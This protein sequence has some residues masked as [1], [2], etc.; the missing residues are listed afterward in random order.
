MAETDLRFRQVHLDFHTSEAI[1]G[2]GAD[3]DPDEFAATLKR[4][5]VD[6]VTCFAR[7]HHGWIYYDTKAF[8]ERRHPG[9]VRPNLLGEQIDACGRRGIRTPLYVTVQWDHFTAEHYPEWLILRHDG[10]IEG[11]PPFEPGFYRSLCVNTPYRDW[12]KR[13]VQEIFDTVRVD[14]FFFDIVGE[15]PCSCWRC[16]AGMR[17]AGLDPSDAGARAAYAADLMA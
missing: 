5:R 4:A 2:V 3:F 15:R 12:L 16:K 7:C 13:H 14:G 11:T 8:P 1:G 10:A 17:A 9:L 6:S